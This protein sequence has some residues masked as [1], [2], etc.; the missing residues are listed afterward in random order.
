MEGRHLVAWNLRRL[1]VQPGLSQETLA[2]DAE[3]DR[4]YLGRLERA[5]EN[6]T[7]GVLDKL[8]G[9][10]SV[11]VSELLRKPLAGEPI[12]KPLRSGR[13]SSDIRSPTKSARAV[14]KR[15]G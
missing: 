2:V 15:R 10:L 12:P 14:R 1:R 4:S 7:V 3:V 6:P 8:A 9:A 11:H 13:R 5:E